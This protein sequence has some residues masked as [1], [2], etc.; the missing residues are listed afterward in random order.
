MKE[1]IRAHGH[2][3]VLAQHDSTLEVTTDDWLTTAGDCILAIEADRAPSDFDDRFVEACKSSSAVIR[4]EITIGEERVT[5]AGT[6]DPGLRFESERSM[7]VRTSDYID[8]RTVMI[9]A[10]AAASD[11]R[12]ELVRSL[13]DGSPV[14]VTLTV[15]DD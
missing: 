7:V 4:C 13:Q 2:P 10:S 1:V 11:I 6:G 9:D 5:V 15:S 3:N 8:D 12:R 14:T